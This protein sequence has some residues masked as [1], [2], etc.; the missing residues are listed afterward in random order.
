MALERNQKEAKSAPG[1]EVQ[2]DGQ[3]NPSERNLPCAMLQ[4]EFGHVSLPYRPWESGVTKA[5]GL[6]RNAASRNLW[7]SCPGMLGLDNFLIQ[8]IWV[9][10][11]RPLT[12][13][14]F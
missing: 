11:I 14:H 9:F 6:R 12:V 8:R 4:S 3:K 2:S 5:G 1:H 10:R 13:S 7:F